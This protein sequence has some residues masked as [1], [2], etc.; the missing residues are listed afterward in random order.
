MTPHPPEKRE[1]TFK[2][3]I[4]RLVSGTSAA[5]AITI[6][7]TPILTRIYSPEA[8]GVAA[9]FAA[10]SAISGVLVCLRYELSIVLPDNDRDAA[11]LLAVSLTFAVVVSLATVPLIWY[12]APQFLA[13]ANM[14][15]LE[16]FIWLIPPILLIHGSFIGLHYW[17][18]RT[19]HFTRLSIA[20]VTNAL[21]TASGS[22]GAGLAGQATGGALI[23]AQIGGT[24]RADL[25]G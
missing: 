11:N 15:E 23:A 14:S 7:V 17:N 20:G 19:K 25:A 2:G 8:F 12:G 1:S 9:L 13:W 10:V 6:L 4:L 24:R 5:A 22:V 18:T 21:A 16:P 3:D